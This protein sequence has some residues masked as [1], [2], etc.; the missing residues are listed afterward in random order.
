MPD[1][2]RYADRRSLLGRRIGVLLD[3]GTGSF[4]GFGLAIFIFGV[5]TLGVLEVFQLDEFN[6]ACDG[7]DDRSLFSW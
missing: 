6:Q 2:A 4:P 7:V 5:L 3:A 1:T